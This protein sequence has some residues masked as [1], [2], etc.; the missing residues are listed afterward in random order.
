MTINERDAWLNEVLRSRA[1]G[2]HFRIAWIL[3]NAL[4]RE[5]TKSLSLMRLEREGGEAHRRSMQRA[6][7]WLEWR[8]LLRVEGGDH[9]SAP[10]RYTMLFPEAGRA[11]A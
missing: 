7:R 4:M 8:G 6:V 5:D 11:A 10:R 3:A 2:G 9:P 1:S